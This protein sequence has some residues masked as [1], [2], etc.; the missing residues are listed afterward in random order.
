ERLWQGERGTAATTQGGVMLPG[1]GP[2]SPTLCD[3]TCEPIKPGGQRRVVVGNLGDVRA[4]MSEH[5]FGKMLGQR[6]IAHHTRDLPMDHM[7]VAREEL[8]VRG[9]R[10]A[11]ERGREAVLRTPGHVC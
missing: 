9:V 2:T 5:L 3:G 7:L 4:R 8:C 11:L 10:A 1:D 6:R